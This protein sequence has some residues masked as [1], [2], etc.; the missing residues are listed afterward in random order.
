MLSLFQTMIHSYNR[1]CVHS[2]TV[3]VIIMYIYHTLI[4]ALSACIIHINLNMIFC[5][6][7]EH[8]PIKNSLHKVLYRNIPTH[9]QWIWMCMTLISIIHH[10]CAHTHTHTHARTHTHALTRTHA[11]THTHTHSDYDCSRNWVLMLVGTKILW[12]EEGF[13]FGFK[14]WQGWTV[15]SVWPPPCCPCTP[16]SCCHMLS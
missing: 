14:R 1:P 7:V 15:S 5:T 2:Q 13:Q 3:I 9:T 12:E 16:I 10:A 11:C 4:N 8:S 6:H